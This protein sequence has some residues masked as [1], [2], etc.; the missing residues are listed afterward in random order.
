[1]VMKSIVIFSSAIEVEEPECRVDSDCS[2]KLVCINENCQNPCA[3]NNPCSTQQV[4]EVKDVFPTKSVSCNCHEGY[5]LDTNGNC[6]Q[7]TDIVAITL[8]PIFNFSYSNA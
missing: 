1:M 2:Y 4:C 7:G 8:F 6:I 3:V 5:L